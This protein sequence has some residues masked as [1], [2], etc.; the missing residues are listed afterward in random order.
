MS[1]PNNRSEALK[2][3]KQALDVWRPDLDEDSTEENAAWADLLD[4]ADRLAAILGEPKP[5]G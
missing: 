5:H 3:I 1:E 4:V 2:L